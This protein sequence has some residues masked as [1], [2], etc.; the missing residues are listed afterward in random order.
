MED[1][2]ADAISDWTARNVCCVAYDAE[3]LIVD[4]EGTRALRAEHRARRLRNGRP[5]AEFAPEWEE[6]LPPEQVLKYFGEWPSAAPNRT[7]V[8]I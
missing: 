3:T 5:Y 8:R 7:V 2:R 6:R 1:L 4:E